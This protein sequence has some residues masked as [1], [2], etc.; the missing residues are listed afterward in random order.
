MSATAD[1]RGLKRV[2]AGCGARYYDFNKRPIKCPGCAVE[3][4]G[5]IKLKARRGRAAAAEAAI[6]ETPGPPPANDDRFEEVEAT[7][8]TISLE[9]VEEAGDKDDDEEI[10]IESDEIE[11][12]ETIDELEEDLEVK[13]EK[14]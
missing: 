12:I 8:N 14:E 3:F 5:E 1:A 6:A 10:G 7:E 11:A 9:E 4:S 2:C 13:V